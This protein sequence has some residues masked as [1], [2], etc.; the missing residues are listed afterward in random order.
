MFTRIF[1]KFSHYFFLRGT[2][3]SYYLPFAAPLAYNKRNLVT[4][5]KIKF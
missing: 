2:I 4:L 1:F 3:F 5:K